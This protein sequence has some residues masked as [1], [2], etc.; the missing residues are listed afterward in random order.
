MA[1]TPK[2]AGGI[3]APNTLT[4]EAT[5]NVAIPNT[6]TGEAVGDVSA[7]NTLT[8]E[9]V[10]TVAAPNTLTGEAVGDIAAP[11]TLSGEAVGDVAAPNTLAS[12][13]VGSVAAPNTVTTKAVGA[14]TAPNTFSG[15]TPAAFPR[16]L[17]P[18][19]DL[20]FAANSFAQ[21]GVAKDSSDILTYSRPSSATFTNRRLDVNGDWEY[22][23]DTDYV[24]DVE[25]L[26][27]YSEQFDNASWIKNGITLS[28]TNK[29]IAPDGTMS[30]ENITSTG[31]ANLYQTKAVA[32]ILTTVSFWVKSNGNNNGFRLRLGSIESAN[33]F[34]TGNWVKYTFTTTP[35]NTILSIR[36]IGLEPLDVYIWGAQLTQSAK[37]LPYVKTISAPVTQTFA[38]TLRVEYNPET[39]ENLGALIEGGS[40]NL[41]LRS[42]EF[43]SAS[44]VKTNITVATNAAIAPDGTYSAD[45]ITGTTTSNFFRQTLTPPA[46]TL[47]FSAWV[48]NKNSGDVTFSMGSSANVAQ[49]T[50]SNEWVRYEHTFTDSGVAQ[51]YGFFNAFG[52]IILD[53]YIWGAQLEA[54]PFASSYIRTEGAA[55]SRSADNLSLPSAGNFNA[56]EYTLKV[57]YTV[58]VDSVQQYIAVVGGITPADAIV[59]NS[60]DNNTFRHWGKAGGSD[61]YRILSGAIPRG[62]H[63]SA[64]VYANNSAEAFMD[65]VSIGSDSDAAIIDNFSHISLG[66]WKGVDTGLYFGHIANFKTYNKAMT[67][68]EVSLL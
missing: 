68:Q 8:G 38:E 7:P 58:K 13:S 20:N 9:A 11:N 16:T 62:F 4:G 14:V 51:S 52:G 30:A 5:G 63:S 37:P 59:M 17:T 40:T 49:F 46:G 33:M 29:H 43:D 42:E 60:Q 1:I 24:G 22:F 55:V 66:Y 23:L 61:E 56:S 34:A 10:G 2:P 39:G 3:A 65:G 45:A 26:L 18:L 27:T 6:L 57:D 21:N 44:W 50:A 12:Q 48:K 35:N 54:L 31:D 67:A 41:L 47:T 19:V 36:N 25:N 64:T 28:S 15:V 32:G 53:L